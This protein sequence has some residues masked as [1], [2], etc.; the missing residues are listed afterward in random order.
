MKT[1][2]III[3]ALPLAEL[4]LL[5]LIHAIAST[6]CIAAEPLR[7]D[8]TRAGRITE[9]LFALLVNLTPIGLIFA[10]YIM[11]ELCNQRRQ[12]A[13]RLFNIFIWTLLAS[14]IAI[15]VL[16]S[17]NNTIVEDSQMNI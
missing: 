14:I 5:W 3:A 7:H 8:E 6:C 10:I 9:C 2:L 17:S 4:A 15:I 12:W 1:T 16:V 11:D 13:L